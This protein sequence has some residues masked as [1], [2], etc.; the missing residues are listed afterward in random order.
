MAK[1][2]VTISAKNNLP[3]GMRGAKRDLDQ[4]SLYAQQLGNKL[5]S[6]LSV[7]SIAAAAAAGVKLLID[8]GR[9]CV[10][11]FTEAE[12]VSKRLTAVWENVGKVT[13]KSVKELDDYAEGMEKVTYFTSESI[14]EAG[15]LLAATESLTEEGFD[16]ALQAS[17]DLAAAM[18]EDVTSAASTLS[19]AIQ[20]PEASLSRLKSIGVSFTDAEKEQIKALTD[21]NKLYEAQDIILGK[22]EGKYRGVAQAIADTPSGKL[23]EIK[24]T[25]GDIRET[26]GEGIMG[27]LSPAF[28]FILEMLHKIHQWAR[29]HVDESKFW[30]EVGT[31]TSHNLYQDYSE[32]FLEKRRADTLQDIAD[33]LE[34]MGSGGWGQFL[35]ENLESPLEDILMIQQDNL[36]QIME[37][38]AKYVYGDNYEDW[39]GTIGGFMEQIND[40]Y[41]PLLKVLNTIDGALEEYANP[42]AIPDF[43]KT[44]YSAGTTG[45]NDSPLA[46]F[47]KAYQ[48]SSESYQLK[49]YRAVIAQAQE[50]YDQISSGS[51]QQ[52]QQMF[53]EAGLDPATT[54]RSSVLR[55]I[56]EIIEDYSEKI[57]GLIQ[58]EEGVKEAAA[59]QID[60]LKKIVTNTEG[61]TLIGALGEGIGDLIANIRASI[62][63][64]ETY[65]TSDQDLSAGSRLMQYALQSFGEAGEVISELSANMAAMGPI[66]GAIVTALKYVIEG[67]AEALG[68]MLHEFI[69]GGLEP[70][71]ELG[72]A[73]GQI[74]LPI[75]KDVMPLVRQSADMLI[76]LFRTLGNILQ[77]VVSLISSLIL[78]LTQEISLY[79]SILE[80]ILKVITGVLASFAG[81][82]AYVAQAIRWIFAEV[83]NWMASWIPWM[84]AIDNPGNPGNFE[85]FVNAYWNNAMAG[86]DTSASGASA[87]TEVAV[88]S[89]AYRGATQVTINI[90]AEGPIVGDGG[91]REFARMIRDEFDALNYYGVN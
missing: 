25:L 12:K 50:L 43:L 68:P 73:I 3:E 34:M 31:S 72:R 59:A 67:L 49:T 16:R 62:R 74:L 26:L 58:E 81:V 6:A 32:S 53:K 57:D 86:W 10:Q 38:Y 70:L 78:P 66:L 28:N 84:D 77:P 89:A 46:A 82:F 17:I 7:A 69:Q 41:E 20:E 11:E 19:R 88:A 90:Y 13:G 45:T 44:E 75:L 47:L 39:L 52:I 80:P 9:K 15:L 56:M 60:P 33:Q 64:E 71:R 18:G 55:E 35:T 2:Q 42:L 5:K 61:K 24:D 1:A 37:Q 22:V 63:G 76:G 21:A 30:D 48:S 65:S 27:A 79:M 87:S 54:T 36:A 91:M 51:A 40:Q 8:A 29:D 83:V 23:D 85:D 4:F 14:K